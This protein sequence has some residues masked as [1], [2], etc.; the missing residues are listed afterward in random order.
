MTSSY[1]CLR[2]LSSP[3]SARSQGAVKTG[4]STPIGPR[5]VPIRSGL[6]GSPTPGFFGAPGPAQVLSPAL[7]RVWQI[8][9]KCA[10][11]AGDD[12]DF[13]IRRAPCTPVVRPLD[14][15][16]LRPALLGADSRLVA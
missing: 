4:G 6:A 5:T 3:G 15:P 1:L 12:P 13:T 14:I 7:T 11:I 9:E 2:P 10:M 16:S 8:R